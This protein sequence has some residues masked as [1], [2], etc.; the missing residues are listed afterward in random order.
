[1]ILNVIQQLYQKP[2]KT[3]DHPNNLVIANSISNSKFQIS[4]IIFLY[5][6]MGGRHS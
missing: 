3:F 5:A 4:F 6:E 1:M 2:Y